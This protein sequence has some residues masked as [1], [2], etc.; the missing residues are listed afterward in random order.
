MT[1]PPVSLKTEKSRPP[2][3]VAFVIVTYHPNWAL[4]H[5]RLTSLR[6]QVDDV[7]VVDNGSPSALDERF[8]AP[9]WSICARLLLDD[10][11]GIAKA[12]NLGIGWA[13]AQGATHVVLLDQDSEP[14]PDMVDHLLRAADALETQV[15]KLGVVAPRFIDERH[16]NAASFFRV[17]GLRIVPVAC[18]EA[19]EYMAIDAAI[20][21]GSLLAV[22]VLA[23]VG[24]MR[25]ELFIDLVDIEWCMRARALGYRS[26]GVCDA[27][28]HHTL[29]ESPRSLFGRKIAHYS[30]LRSYYFYRNGVWLFRQRYM[31]IAWKLAVVRQLVLRYLFYSVSVAPRLGYL[32]M[33]TLGLWHG[34]RGRLGRRA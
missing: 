28:L 27:V 14:A 2:R 17:E 20:A 23:E 22:D 21:S 33:M 13:I 31:P 7:V 1:V 32:R 24:G 15:Q 19:A 4:V 18:A 16:G 5:S 8:D 29:G 25:E 3:K 26:F 30:P 10:N 12:Q 9:M 11:Y 6:L 34:L